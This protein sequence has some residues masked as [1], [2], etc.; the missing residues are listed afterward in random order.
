MAT[1]LFSSTNRTDRHDITEISIGVRHHNR[2]PTPETIDGLV[3]QA[4]AFAELQQKGMQPINLG[5]NH[6]NKTRETCG[7]MYW[8]R[9]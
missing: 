6:I 5:Q 1:F 2:N 4:K 9:M 8:L 7:D 3:N